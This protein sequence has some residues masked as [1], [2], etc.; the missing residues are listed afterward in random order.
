M[1]IYRIVFC[2]FTFASLTPFT[3]AQAKKPAAGAPSPATTPQQKPNSPCPDAIYQKACDSY[4]ELLKAKDDG[5]R[6]N[7][8]QGGVALVCFR[9]DA[10]SFFVF[11][12]G[13]PLWTKGHFD[14]DKKTYLPD[15]DAVSWQVGTV[16]EFVDGISQNRTMHLQVFSGDWS[17][18][19][20]PTFVADK[21]N[22]QATD[23]N[24]SSLA[25]DRRQV[26]GTL[27]YKNALNKNM[28]YGLV[29]QRSTGRFTETYTQEGEQI[30][31]LEQQGRCI[32]PP[33]T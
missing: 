9:K 10:D 8:G 4:A 7:V 17:L 5:V 26:S 22:L 13:G 24:L 31:T 19:D 2:A 25:V 6:I 18:P 1:L 14:A 11:R 27:R 16:V 12:L 23:N 21:I 33:Q 32:V 15:H 28:D 29:I 20:D 3:S 30:P